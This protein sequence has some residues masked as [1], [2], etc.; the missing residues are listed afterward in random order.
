MSIA[1]ELLSLIIHVLIFLIQFVFVVAFFCFIFSGFVNH[2]DPKSELF[3]LTFKI[4]WQSGLTGMLLLV[5][6]FFLT[7]A[8]EHWFSETD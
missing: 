7:V 3:D 1:K 2:F 8:L 5:L 6:A 4:F